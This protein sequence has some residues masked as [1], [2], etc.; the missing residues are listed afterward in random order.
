MERARKSLR[1]KRVGN[2]P[3]PLLTDAEIEDAANGLY[4]DYRRAG[5]AV[6]LGN[7]LPV[8]IEDIAEHFLGYEIDFTETGIFSDPDVMGGID[9]ENNKI[10]VNTS[11]ADHDGRYSFTVAHEIGH[12]VLHR[13]RYLQNAAGCENDILCRE[14]GKKPQIEVEA[15]RFAAALLMPT[16]NLKNAVGRKVREIRTVGQARALANDLITEGG[17]NNVSNSAMIN[18][19]KDLGHLKKSIPYQGAKSR[20]TYGPPSPIKILKGALKK[21]R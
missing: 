7:N 3:Y 21:W 11:V 15:D 10:Y 12:H 2:N 18:R 4:Y 19:L 14:R 20:K 5:E 13:D 9:F 8:P 17:F 16:E 6:S 1:R